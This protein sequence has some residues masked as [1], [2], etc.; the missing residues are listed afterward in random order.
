MSKWF[1]SAKDLSDSESS[2]SSDEEKKVV[3]KKTV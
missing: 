1:T 2:D 3:A